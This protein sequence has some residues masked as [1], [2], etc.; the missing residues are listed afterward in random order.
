MESL[1][2]KA[3]A[4]IEELKKREL[5]GEVWAFAEKKSLLYRSKIHRVLVGKDRGFAIRWRKER[6]GGFF[7]FS[8]DGR[9]DPDSYQMLISDTINFPLPSSV[10]SNNVV[11]K[12]PA[13]ITLLR[14]DLEL[15]DNIVEYSEV[16]RKV[17]LF[18]TRGLKGDYT[19]TLFRYRYEEVPM[20]QYDVWTRK[21]SF[22]NPLKGIEEGKIVLHPVVTYRVLSYLLSSQRKNFKELQFSI[23]E[24]PERDYAPG[25]YPFDAIGMEMKRRAIFR[26]GKFVSRAPVNYFRLEPALPPRIFWSNIELELPRVECDEFRII[27]RIYIFKEEVALGEDGEIIIKGGINELV[28]RIVGKIADGWYLG[29]PFIK[30]DYLLLE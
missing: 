30:S 5:E 17:V 21:R 6:G 22:I 12:D 23:V 10:K 15:S 28:S 3:H 4:I 25:S 7:F 20:F 19:E 24:N 16:E 13:G 26:R 27:K 1:Y 18:N 29:P 14:E 8:K 2:E 11:V 9:F